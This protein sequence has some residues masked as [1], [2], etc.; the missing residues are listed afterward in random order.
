TLKIRTG[1]C[2]NDIVAEDIVKMAQN[3]GIEFV[4]I[5][6]RTRAQKYNGLANWPLINDIAGKYEIPIIGNGDLHSSVF[7]KK[8]LKKTNCKALM[9]GRGPLRF[10]FIFLES[11]TE[12]PVDFFPSDHMEIIKRLHGYM[13]DYFDH[14]KFIEI[15]LKKHILWMSAG[16]PGAK[17]FRRLLFELRGHEQVVNYACKYLDEIGDIQKN[18]NLQEPFLSGGEG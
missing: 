11:M 1:W 7:V 14:P 15:Q 6:G 17:A 12:E 3:E 8:E 10:P 18:I 4:A 16:Y 9:L 2:A 13:C 5:H